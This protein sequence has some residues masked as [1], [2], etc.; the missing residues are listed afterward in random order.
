LVRDT[1]NTG[2]QVLPKHVVWRCETISTEEH[3]AYFHVQLLI[4]SLFPH[5]PHWWP[6][7]E[8]SFSQ[9]IELKMDWAK[10]MPLV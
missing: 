6:N 5:R 9:D 10:A 7:K 2:V 8:F 3:S 4:G 1:N